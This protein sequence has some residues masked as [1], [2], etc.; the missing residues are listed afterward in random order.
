MNCNLCGCKLTKLH[1]QVLVCCEDCFYSL[2]AQSG[3]A[4]CSE[5]EAQPTQGMSQPTEGS[6]TIPGGEADRNA[7]DDRMSNANSVDP[8]VEGDG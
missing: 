8:V 1:E 7:P 4:A 3:E 2:A 6:A 5:G